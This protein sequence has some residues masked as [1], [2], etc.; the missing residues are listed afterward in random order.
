M[1]FLVCFLYVIITLVLSSSYI[2]PHS[3]PCGIKQHTWLQEVACWHIV[4]DDTLSYHAQVSLRTQCLTSPWKSPSKQLHLDHLQCVTKVTLQFKF[5]RRRRQKAGLLGE[6]GNHVRQTC[7]TNAC[8]SVNT[9]IS[10]LKVTLLTSYPASGLQQ[11]GLTACSPNQWYSL[12][13]RLDQFGWE[14]DVCSMIKSHTSIHS[15][16]ELHFKVASVAALETIQTYTRTLK[17][18]IHIGHLLCMQHFHHTTF[19]LNHKL[20]HAY[21]QNLLFAWGVFLVQKTW[22]L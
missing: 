5:H 1:N 15:L 12:T 20:C 16:S 4:Y 10:M 8:S 11:C 19:S 14:H 9:E 17:R 6:N 21:L 7:E 3:F 22:I 18:K 2:F 13:W